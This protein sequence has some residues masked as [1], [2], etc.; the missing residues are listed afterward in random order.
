MQADILVRQIKIRIRI[1]PIHNLSWN[2]TDF[3]QIEITFE[4][5]LDLPLS[6]DQDLNLMGS[7][8][9]HPST[10]FGQKGFMTFWVILQTN[11][12]TRQ[13]FH[14]GNYESIK[15]CYLSIVE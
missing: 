11:E 12:Q 3:F 8:L 2:M 7:T 5:I 4:D 15:V 1:A 9:P 14:K 10:T 13:S 6:L